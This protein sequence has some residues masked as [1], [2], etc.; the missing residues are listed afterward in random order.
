MP[1]Y[2]VRVDLDVSA[3]NAGDARGRIQVAIYQ[4]ARN[5][6]TNLLDLKHEGYGTLRG[7]DVSQDVHEMGD[8]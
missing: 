8:P 1:R 2:R 4:L 6:T 7:Y 3:D 5:G